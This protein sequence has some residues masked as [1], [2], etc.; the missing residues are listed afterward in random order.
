MQ[1]IISHQNIDFDGLASMVACS[2]LHPNA[3]MYFTGK[4]SEEV[5]KFMALYKNI[6]TIPQ[7]GKLDLKQIEGLFIVD[8][9]NGKRVGKFNELIGQ[10]IPITVYDHHPITEHAIGA[11]HQII[12]PYGSCTAILLEEIIEKDI[13]ITSFEATLLA[14]GIYTDTN[15][16][17]FSHTTYQDAACVAYL[18]KNGANLMV[19]N[20]FLKST[21][22]PQQDELLTALMANIELVNINGYQ[23]MISILERDEFIGELGTLAEKILDIKKCDGLF[24]VVKMEDRCYIIGRSLSEE[25]V[26]PDILKDYGGGGHRKAA[27]ASVKDG[28]VHIIREELLESIKSKTKPQITAKDIMSYPVKTVFEDM[29]V[30]EVNGIML[31]YGHTGMPVVKEDTLIGIIS[32]TDIDKAMIHGLGHAPVK[33]FMTHHV[34]AI[35]LNT[36]VTE[37]NNLFIKHNIGRL[38]VMKDGIIIGIVTRTDLLKVLHGSNYP[39]WYK[40]T[41]DIVEEEAPAEVSCFEMLQSLPTDIYHILDVA[42]NVGDQ[43]DNKVFVVGGFVRDLLLKRDNWDIDIVIEGD[44]IDFAKRLN[45][46]LKGSIKL[47]EQFGTAMI[48]LENGQT[49]DI[50]TARREY[51]EYPAAL[52]KVEKSSI[53][54]DL[55]RRDFTINCMAIQLNKEAKGRLIDFFGGLRDLK[56]KKIRVLY[57]LSFIEDPTRIFRA[58]RF[59]SRL[60]FIIDPETDFFMRQAIEDQMI[61]KLSDDRIRDELNYLLREEAVCDNLLQLQEHGIL[62]SLHLGLSLNEGLLKKICSLDETIHKFSEIYQGPFHKLMLVV[63]QL[64]SNL[65][66]DE[67]MEIL[68]KFIINKSLTQRIH[69]ALTNR[70]KVYSILRE[71]E[72]DRFTLYQLLQPLDP[73]MLL[74]YYNDSEDPYVKHYLMFFSLKLKDI[75]LELTGKDLQGFGIKPG[76]IYKEILDQLL[77]KKVMGELYSRED[78]LNYAS[79]IIR[80]MKGEEDVSS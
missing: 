15:C 20:E 41:F 32:R 25:I 31:R 71:E 66:I 16:L 36:S 60:G 46:Q 9:N 59:A 4:L 52:P 6:L 27:S 42:G 8:V 17:T 14:L 10:G 19:V 56:E 5:K 23:V 78:E 33:G 13:K 48:T 35:D 62:Q 80:K 43:L 67:A 70:D 21:L 76:P 54:S 26:I 28:N 12:K 47:F 72:V 18:L 49:L 53:W 68:T 7:A 64:L 74:Y 24:L 75:S 34:K 77:Q 50:V 29:T 37:I 30:E 51:Y 44:G 79:K 22:E 2:K 40:K 55:F 58:I 61:K 3:T 69:T 11:D 45:D 1:V 39:Y 57:N 63:L 65:P 73:D 38:P